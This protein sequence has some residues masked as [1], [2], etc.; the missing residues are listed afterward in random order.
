MSLAAI[1]GGSVSAYDRIHVEDLVVAIVKVAIAY[2]GGSVCL[3]GM[4]LPFQNPG[5][6]PDGYMEFRIDKDGQ[7]P[8]A[9]SVEFGG[10]EHD[11][12]GFAD[13]TL[14]EL[15]ERAEGGDP[16]NLM[17]SVFNFDELWLFASMLVQRMALSSISIA[18]GGLGGL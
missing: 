14:E 4:S 3:H 15:R 13:L 9:F 11:R 16:V 18:F 10:K 1:C 8:I 6:A 7:S 2:T 5:D 12:L 17:A